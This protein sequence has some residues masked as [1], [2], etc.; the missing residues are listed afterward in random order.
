MCAPLGGIVN[1]NLSVRLEIDKRRNA[2]KAGWSRLGNFWTS[3]CRKRVK[4]SVLYANVVEP[5][6]SGLTAVVPTRSQ[7][8]SLTAVLCKFL[9]VLEQGKAYHQLVRRWAKRSRSL[10]GT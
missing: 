4:R 8:E 1:F 6:L 10:W 3:H 2:M 5:A 9:R 7:M